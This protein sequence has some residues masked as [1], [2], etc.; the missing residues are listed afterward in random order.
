MEQ[1]A[2]AGH[3][4]DDG[5]I[6]STPA[7]GIDGDIVSITRLPDAQDYVEQAY[8]PVHQ[9]QPSRRP[10]RNFLVRKSMQMTSL[11][12]FRRANN[13][14]SSLH[15]STHVDGF[16]ELQASTRRSNGSSRLSQDLTRNHFYKS[17]HVMERV[18]DGTHYGSNLDDSQVFERSHEQVLSSHHHAT[19]ESFN[20]NDTNT[21]I[22]KLPHIA[23]QME[24]FKSSSGS[25]AAPFAVN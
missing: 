22:S 17:E 25:K 19:Q 16:H 3:P 2:A 12:G 7:R 21:S 11:Q 10:G 24:P 4:I 20:P 9:L 18:M 15:R 14:K 23:A 13:K 5:W 8:E 6:E 1:G